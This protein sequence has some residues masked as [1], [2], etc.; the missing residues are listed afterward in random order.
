[1]VQKLE[2]TARR[3]ALQA[4]PE[5]REVDG[6]DAIF[7]TFRF[8]DFS[9]AFGFMVRAALAA[10]RMDHHPE[11]TNVYDRVEVTL[12]THDAAGVTERDVK[13]AMIM[14]RIAAETGLVE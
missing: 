14:D 8:K 9:S 11:W 3:D 7:R 12:T 10:D 5:W 1:M 13:L 4:L 6:R 2:G